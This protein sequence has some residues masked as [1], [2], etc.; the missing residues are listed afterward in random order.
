MDR[1]TKILCMK[2]ILEHLGDC[3]DEWQQADSQDE[4]YLADSIE[5]DLNEFRRLCHS[6]RR[7][8]G[9]QTPRRQAAFA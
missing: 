1:K 7:D 3:F 4:R 6:M 5:R 2:D 9:S 8:T